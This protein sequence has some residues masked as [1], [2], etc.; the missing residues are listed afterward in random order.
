MGEETLIEKIKRL[1]S[2]IAW[3]IFLWSI[4]R[5]AEDYWEDIYREQKLYRNP[6]PNGK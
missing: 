4:S 1:V 6:T 3:P 2:S 5:T